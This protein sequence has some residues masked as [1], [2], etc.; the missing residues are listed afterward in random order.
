MHRVMDMKILHTL[1]SATPAVVAAA[2][3]L[4]GGCAQLIEVNPFIDDAPPSGTVYTASTAAG[5]TLILAEASMP[6]EPCL[7]QVLAGSTMHW[8]HLVG[9]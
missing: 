9:A 6:G 3:L 8:S 7:V 1:S 2:A 5:W 4:L